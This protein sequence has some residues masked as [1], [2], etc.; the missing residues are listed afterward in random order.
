MSRT[1]RVTVHG[2]TPM[3]LEFAPDDPPV[4]P[5]ARTA[6]QA[7]ALPIRRLDRPR[8]TVRSLPPTPADRDRGARRGE[9]V[10]GGWRFEV[11]VEDAGQA[12]LR[13]RTARLGGGLSGRARLAV[14]AQIP[15]RIV[16]VDV[17]VGDE[18]EAGQRLL[19]IEAMKMENELRASQPGTV[20]RVLVTPGATVERGQELVVI[21]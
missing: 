4:D 1:L 3:V 8:G 9:V 21:T 17:A 18:V 10:V 19:S 2:S 15:G 7:Q 14:L 6:D 5:L 13:E 20:A 16:R 11:S 12:A